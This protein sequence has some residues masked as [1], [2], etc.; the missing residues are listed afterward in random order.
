ME[1]IQRAIFWAIVVSETGHVFCCVLPTII[2][3][4]S[5]L[6]GVGMLSILPAGILAFHEL[7]HKWELPM[8]AL[9]AAVLGLGWILNAISERIDCHSTGCHHGP[10]KPKKLSAKGILIFATALFVFNT[11]I[12]FLFHY[13]K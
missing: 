3:L 5:L 2:S 11:A 10:C 4:A 6:A 1:R 7:M 9:S 8:I 12:Y 13:G